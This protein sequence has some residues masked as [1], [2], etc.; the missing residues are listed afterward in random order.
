MQRSLRID[1]GNVLPN[2]GLSI[3]YTEGPPP[4]PM[5]QSGSGMD[6]ESKQALRDAIE[7][8]VANMPA[9]LLIAFAIAAVYRQNPQLPNSALAQMIGRTVNFDLTGA[10]NAVTFS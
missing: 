5:E 1:G 3:R 2:G 9:E 8:A 10:A 6:F 7:M 4:L